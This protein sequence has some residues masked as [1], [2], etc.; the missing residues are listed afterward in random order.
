[1]NEKWKAVPGFDNYIV[2]NLGSVRRKFRG[3]WVPVIPR[4]ATRKDRYM[5]RKVFDLWKDG[6]R[7]KVH[8]SRVVYSAFSGEELSKDDWI[9]MENGDTLDC[10]YENLV[11]VP[12]SV[13]CSDRW[14]RVRAQGKWAN[15]PNKNREL[16]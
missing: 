8:L 10:R 12:K 2:S 4:V 11:K 5:P 3:V 15:W 6:K 7:K 16:G 13:V 9:M 1:M 14:R